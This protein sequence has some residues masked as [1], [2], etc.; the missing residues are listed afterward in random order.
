[1]DASRF[2]PP[3]LTAHPGPDPEHSPIGGHMRGKEAEDTPP[4]PS[5]SEEG[6][7]CHSAAHSLSALCEGIDDLHKGAGCDGLTAGLCAP[8]RCLSH[9]GI[10]CLCGALRQR[11]LQLVCRRHEE[12]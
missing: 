1:P 6:S 11:R 7:C 12:R 9:D 10:R 3:L 2:L 4:P 8:E 5:P